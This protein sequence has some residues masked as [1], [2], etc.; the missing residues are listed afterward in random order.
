[1]RSMTCAMRLAIDMQRAPHFDLLRGVQ[2][3]RRI[4]RTIGED[5]FAHRVCHAIVAR[6]RAQHLIRAVRRARRIL[7][8]RRIK[9]DSHASKQYAY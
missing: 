8:H 7:P 6:K 5:I 4:I 2:K 3:R 1:M 9:S